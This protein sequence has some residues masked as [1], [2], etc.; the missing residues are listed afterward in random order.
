MAYRI[1]QITKPS[2]CHVTNHHLIVEQEEGKADIPLE[3]IQIIL[4]IGAK[5]RFSTMGLGELGKEGIVIVCFGKKH[6]PE[7][8][9]E[10]YHPNARHSRMLFEQIRMEQDFKD[11]LWNMIIKSKILNQSRNLAVLGVDGFEKIAS[12]EQYIH[13]GDVDNIEALAAAE[14][15]QFYHKGLNRRTDAPMNSALNYGY[16]IIRSYIIKAMITTGFHCALGI[17]HHNDFNS[18]NLADDLIEP[19]RAMVDQMA[20]RMSNNEL[21]LNSKERKEL[22]EILH[23]NCSIDEKTMWISTGIEIMVDSLKNAIMKKEP[24]LLK[25]PILTDFR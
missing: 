13:N 9:I 8:L 20:Y 22:V 3:D 17:H 25:L 18:F 14:Y 16:A 11:I 21:I 23:C 19:W 1:V 15:F 24:E 4:C 2:E 5:I 10:P 6:E 12:Y 7:I